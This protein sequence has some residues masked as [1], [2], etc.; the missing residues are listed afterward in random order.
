VLDEFSIPHDYCPVIGGTFQV[1]VPAGNST[2]SLFES[3]NE[4]GTTTV[5]DITED[6]AMRKVEFSKAVKIY[7]EDEVIVYEPE[8]QTSNP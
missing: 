7:A 2:I 8:N 5:N 6:Q 1:I 3:A 4:I